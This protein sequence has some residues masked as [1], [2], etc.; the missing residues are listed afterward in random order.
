MS[1]TAPVRT[2][3]DLLTSP[4]PFR[5]WLMGRE[6]GR[7]VGATCRTYACPLAWFLSE[8][9]GRSVGVTRLGVWAALAPS[10]VPLCRLPGWA[11]RFA[12]TLD[13][14]AL[15]PGSAVTAADALAALDRADG[16]A[17]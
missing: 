6:P 17:R 9:L 8:R 7:P 15:D 3:A 5:A 4:A 10:P 13:A 1:A 14:A 2:A 16:R 11:A 12:S